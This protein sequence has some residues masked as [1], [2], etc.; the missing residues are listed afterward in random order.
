VDPVLRVDDVDGKGVRAIAL[1]LTQRCWR[2]PWLALDF[3]SRNDYSI[4][5]L[6]TSWFNI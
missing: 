4:D 2:P 5:R 6:T 3:A 1:P